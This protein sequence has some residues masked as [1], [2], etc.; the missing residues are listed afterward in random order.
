M[1][2][3]GLVR[4]LR[5][6]LRRVG[7]W[8]RPYDMLLDARRWR[9]QP[10]QRCGFAQGGYVRGLGGGDSVPFRLS[11]GEEILTR[12]RAAELGLRVAWDVVARRDARSAACRQLSTRRCPVAYGVEGCPQVCARFESDDE[13]PWLAGRC[14]D[15][16]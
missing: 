16:G 3:E 1:M 11:P 15:D 6:W 4:E 13:G 2:F 7:Y 9:W 12:E 8:F 14:R 5:W 10:R